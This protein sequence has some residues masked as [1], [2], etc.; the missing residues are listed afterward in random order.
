ML[1]SATSPWAPSPRWTFTWYLETL[2]SNSL[3]RKSISW[4]CQVQTQCCL[5]TGAKTPIRQWNQD[6]RSF[7]DETNDNLQSGSLLQ[8]TEE[9]HSRNHFRHEW[10]SLVSITNW[11]QLVHSTHCTKLKCQS[12]KLMHRLCCVGT[13]SLNDCTFAWDFKVYIYSTF[14]RSK[15]VRSFANWSSANSCLCFSKMAFSFAV[16]M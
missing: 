3:S 6:F 12:H 15:S 11:N 14:L 5:Q 4:S 8:L 2:T 16:T 7:F 13:T 10:R 9:L 1:D